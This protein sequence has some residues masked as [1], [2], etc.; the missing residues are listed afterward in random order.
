MKAIVTGASGFIGSWMVLELINNSY[1]VLI[2]VR[3]KKKLISE[4]IESKK[5][6]IVEK[7]I[8][9]LEIED[10]QSFNNADA[11]YDFAW[12]GVKPE[13]KNNL[14]MQLKNIN[15]SLKMIEL[16]RAINCQKFVSA[17]SVAEYALEKDVMDI[18]YKASPIDYY[19]AAKASTRL[20]LEVRAKQLNIPFNWVVISS[21]YG[22]RRVDDNIL[23]YTIKSL[24]NGD[25]P[26]YGKLSQIWNFMY[27]GET[28]KAIR[29]IGERG[30][31]GKAYAVGSNERCTLKEFVIKI[32]D[33]IRPN[34]QLQITDYSKEVDTKSSCVNIDELVKDTGF[35]PKISFEEGMRKTIDWFSEELKKDRR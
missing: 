29:L 14:E 8:N 19:G 15:M 10:I 18:H 32:R 13:Q 3:D 35:Q 21:T 1:E 4:I 6:T 25:I 26:K 5:I 2:I 30:K 33:M 22:E 7:D 20:F 27:V 12:V 23:S 34:G 24:I 28:V 11:C 31:N 16:C 17:G 9:E